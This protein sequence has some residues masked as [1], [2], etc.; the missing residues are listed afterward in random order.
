LAASLKDL[1]APPGKTPWNIEGKVLE[2]RPGDFLVTASI[3]ETGTF[4]ILGRSGD[5]TARVKWSI[6]RFAASPTANR[7][8]RCWRVHADCGPFYGSA[9]SLPSTA[10]GD[11][12]FYVDANYA[13][14]GSTVGAQTSIWTWNGR[15]ARLLAVGGHLVMIEDQ[16]QIEF[17][18]QHLVVPTKE[19]PRSF[20]TVGGSLDPAGTWTVRLTPDGAEDLGHRWRD[21]ELQW[22]DELFEALR[23]GRE[24][25]RLAAPE[26][27]R[28]LA[29]VLGDLD[30]LLMDWTATGGT[31]EVFR[32]ALDAVTLTFTLQRDGDHRYATAVT[33]E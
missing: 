24:T 14:N 27:V 11:A 10:A 32:I 20:S 21:P 22:A 26:V 7:K 2:V 30:S 9:A 25:T 5:G 16:R 17:D 31:P 6:D 13:G 19:V 28:K 3:F 18:G 8:L 23:K 33:V 1:H 15:D 29:P 4:F 12:R